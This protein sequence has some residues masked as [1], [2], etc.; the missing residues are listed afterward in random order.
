[1]SKHTSFVRFIVLGFAVIAI[2]ALS[3]AAASSWG[4]NVFASIQEFLGIQTASSNAHG[5]QN[6][7]DQDEANASL[8][9]AGTFQAP[10]SFTAGTRP[11]AVAIGDFNND[12]KPDMA[13]TNQTSNN[14][15]VLLNNGNAANGDPMFKA[16]INLPVGDPISDLDL[17]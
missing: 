2:S 5:G 16:A 6:S 7:S 8:I 9:G 14:V 17:T 4:I 1:M 10:L 3:V 15:S 13:V 11:A 12:G